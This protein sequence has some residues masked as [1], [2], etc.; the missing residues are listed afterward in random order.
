M[1]NSPQLKVVRDSPAVFF[2]ATLRYEAFRKF[3]QSYLKKYSSDAN[4][5]RRIITQSDSSAAKL[6][7]RSRNE[8]TL[9]TDQSSGRCP[10]CGATVEDGAAGCEAM[11]NELGARDFSDPRYVATHELLVDAYCLQ[12]PGRYCSSAKS[13]A[14]HLT[15]MCCGIEYGGK[16]EI[17]AAIPRW[18]S[19]PAKIERPETLTQRG[20]MTIAT[21]A[22][23]RAAVTPEEHNRLVHAWAENVWQAYTPQHEI[24]RR[25]IKAALE[26]KS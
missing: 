12:H 26:A 11:F 4:K 20:S 13:Y 19:G 21:I 8:A 1:F 3:V 15:R 16:R 14:A 9:N 24:A 18:L 23:L 25:W 2:G 6:Q 7:R 22:D 17:Y 10:E 5:N